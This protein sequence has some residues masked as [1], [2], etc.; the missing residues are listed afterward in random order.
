MKPTSSQGGGTEAAGEGWWRGIQVPWS[1]RESPRPDSYQ[2][3]FF[4]SLSF[5]FLFFYFL[6]FVFFFLFFP[7]SF[8][9]FILP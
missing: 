6:F 3:S 5:F 4:F 9:D 7:Q 8:L 2:V 1:P